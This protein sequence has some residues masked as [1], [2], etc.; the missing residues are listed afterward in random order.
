MYRQ[1]GQYGPLI[2]YVSSRCIQL[3]DSLL[4]F[5]PGFLQTLSL[6][7]NNQ[8]VDTSHCYLSNAPLWMTKQYWNTKF[9]YGKWH[10]LT[11]SN[12]K[13]LY[14]I[15]RSGDMVKVFASQYMGRGFE[16]FM[17]SRPWVLIRHRDWE[18]QGS[19]LWE[20]V[21]HHTSKIN[22]GIQSF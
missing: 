5:Y 8:G 6:S 2:I 9:F 13:F 16:P 11:F 19:K 12:Y 14:L 18:I 15:G 7:L 10:N 3:V 4:G 21:S 22:T 1:Q 20:L 17:V